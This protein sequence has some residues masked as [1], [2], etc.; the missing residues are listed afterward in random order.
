M[1]AATDDFGRPHPELLLELSVWNDEIS[2]IPDDSLLDCYKLALELSDPDRPFYPGLMAS[3]FAEIRRREKDLRE[4][5]YRQRLTA[6]P[7]CPHCD[8]LGYQPFYRFDLKA[9][10]YYRYLRPCCCPAT[11]DMQR[12]RTPLTAPLYTRSAR[13]EYVLFEELQT[14][15]KPAVDFN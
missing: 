2:F 4:A 13:G 3:A 11:P 14:Y 8:D 9:Q 12:S 6:E 15:G 5:D 1:I 7:E 10:K